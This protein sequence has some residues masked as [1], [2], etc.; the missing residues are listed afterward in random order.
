MRVGAHLVEVH[1]RPM[2]GDPVGFVRNLGEQVLPR[3]TDL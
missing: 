2:D 3:V 1:V